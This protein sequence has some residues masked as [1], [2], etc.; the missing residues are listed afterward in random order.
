MK[1]V[2]TPGTDGPET[3]SPVKAAESCTASSLPPGQ[4]EPQAG[5]ILTG[6]QLLSRSVTLPGGP[7]PAGN[8]EA[9]IPVTVEA[10]FFGSGS[11]GARWGHRT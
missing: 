5:F 7:G 8:W 9:H 6:S 2:W 11:P 4:Q 3:E 10:P 1:G